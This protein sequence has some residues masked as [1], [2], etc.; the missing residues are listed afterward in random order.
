LD[1]SVNLV[2][3]RHTHLLLKYFIDFGRVTIHYLA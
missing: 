1:V 3:Q 2:I